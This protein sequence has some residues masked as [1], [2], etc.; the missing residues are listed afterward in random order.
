MLRSTYELIR[1]IPLKP[2]TIPPSGRSWTAADLLALAD[3]EN[4][5]EIAQ[6]ELIV[7]PC[8]RPLGDEFELAMSES[9]N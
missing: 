2:I 9:I 7:M 5:Y 1:T 3:E 8:P 4:R 6:G